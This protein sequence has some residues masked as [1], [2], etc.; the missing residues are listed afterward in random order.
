MNYV[1]A[2]LAAA[3]LACGCMG[4]GSSGNGTWAEVQPLDR[5]LA[6]SGKV[7]GL[8]FDSPANGDVS[9]DTGLIEHFSA[10]TK[11]DEIA[12][13]GHGKLPGPNDDAFY[14][15]LPDPTLGLVAIDASA[16]N[17]VTSSDHGAS[18]HYGP[19]Y[20]Q[21]SAPPGIPLTFP[22]LAI[23]EDASG[24]WHVADTAGGVWS[25]P[26]PPGPTA[27]FT[28]TWHPE[29]DVTVPGTIP[30]GDCMMYV[31]NG[32]YALD[33]G[34]MFA[35][36]PDGKT[37]VYGGKDAICRSTDGGN[38]FADVSANITP[39][40]FGSHDTP[41]IVTFA[42]AT[43]GIAAFGSELS[44]PQSA[45]VLYTADAGDHWTV[46]TLPPSAVNQIALIGAFTS[47][48]G[49]LFL[50]GSSV[51]ENAVSHPLLYKSSDHGA[52]WTDLSARLASLSDAP[53]HL[54]T[55]FALDDQHIWVGGEA[56]F[57]AYSATGG[58]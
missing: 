12:L 15:F 26:T 38:T 27:T 9:F 43:S 11:I 58:E 20:G 8:W 54:V 21:A 10:P 7:T 4:G 32:Y 22:L 52:T 55:G 56:G 24:V 40:S 33:P 28:V 48:A 6:D 17:L 25:S 3:S 35:M 30:Q 45:Y 13:D 42:D 1:F 46:A 47:P 50:V 16:A 18:F 41:W 23:G 39:S 29:G 57:I 14:G 44:G 51:D 5:S 49:S 19:M 53:M 34:H 37:M 31:V 2:T 36:T